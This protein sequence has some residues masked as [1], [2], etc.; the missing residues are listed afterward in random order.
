MSLLS[1]AVHAVYLVCAYEYYQTLNQFLLVISFEYD[2][3]SNLSVMK[4]HDPSFIHNL[5]RPPILMAE[6]SKTGPFAP[7]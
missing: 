3:N 7:C 5:I 1:T 4:T 2:N 6:L